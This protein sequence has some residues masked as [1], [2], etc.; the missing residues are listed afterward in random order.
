MS[1]ASDSRVKVALG[2]VADP[3]LLRAVV[4]RDDVSVF[5]LAS[6]VSAGCELDFD[7][8][9]S[10]NLDGCRAVL[11]ACRARRSRP[12]LVFSSAGAAFGGLVPQMSFRTRPSSYP[13]QPMV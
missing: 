9:L 13:K 4:D 12:R 7:G 10:V 6:M 8:A 5:H 11:E 3:E 1:V 2:N